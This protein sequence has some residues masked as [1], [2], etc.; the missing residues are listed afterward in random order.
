MSLDQNTQLLSWLDEEHRRDK[1]TIADLTSQLD[2]H[3]TSINGLSRSIQDLEERLARL[4]SQSLRYSQ[5]EQALGQ[6]KTEVTLLFEQFNQ[7]IQQRED[8]A[9]KVRQRERERL[10]K[11]IVEL[12]AKM[13]E[14]S[15]QWRPFAPDH[16]AIRRLENGQIPLVRG[17]EDLSKRQ[18]SLNARLSVTEEWVKR[19][20]ALIAEIQQL[21]ERLRQ[22]RADALE[23]QR[24]SDQMR[25]RQIT[26]WNEQMKVSKREMEDWVSKLI[27]MLDLPKEVRSSLATLKELES[28]L[29]QVEPRL[30]QRQK[31]TEEFSRTEIG[32][33]KVEMDKRL[34]T[35]TKD[36]EYWK[37]DFQKK[38]ATAASRFEPLEEWRPAV[39]EQFREIRERMEA[40]RLR[41]LEVLAD[42]VRMG[43]EWQRA[44]NMRYDQ[45]S[46]DLIKRVE[47]AQSTAKVKRP[48]PPKGP[49]T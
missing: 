11:A 6:V 24:R 26:E 17:L 48:A 38:L 28:D 12:T 32:S 33:M 40:D 27:P 44:E 18:E 2:Q 21:A 45:M 42:V 34:S 3:L 35:N 47:T 30:V 39:S 22:D 7:R 37:D 13:D 5:I 16:E 25:A 43:V 8:E 9:F 4:Q 46:S 1:A 19:T 10:D 23:S 31:L 29:K 41:W 14:V 15:Q 36:W 20:G 49:E